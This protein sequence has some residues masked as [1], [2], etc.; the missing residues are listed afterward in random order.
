MTETLA[1]EFPI[2]YWLRKNF[3]SKQERQMKMGAI[4][5]ASVNDVLIQLYS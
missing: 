2:R 1:S 4:D 5:A 3:I